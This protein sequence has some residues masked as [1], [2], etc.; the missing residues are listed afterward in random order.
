MR[1]LVVED[2]TAVQSFHKFALGMFKEMV[3]DTALDGVAALKLL[4]EHHYD[5]VLLDINLPLMD[6]VKV[7]S[8]MKRKGGRQSETPVIMVTSEAD[9]GTD[10][11]VMDLGAFKILH[12]PVAAHQIRD[13]VNEA[14][15]QPAAEPPEFQE[16]RSAPRLRIELTAMLSSAP[17]VELVTFDISPHGAFLITDSPLDVGTSVML[18]IELPHLPEP[19]SVT[20]TVAHR[21]DEPAGVMPAGFGV[22]FDHDS[23][24]QEKALEKAFLLTAKKSRPE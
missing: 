3:L 18:S 19:L 20:A 13:A 21:R 14:M 22:R 10:Q 24:E 7:L 12:K 4:A 1:V 8:S 23:P 5:V 9:A 11:Q 15:N 17:S 6:G 16:K 2:S